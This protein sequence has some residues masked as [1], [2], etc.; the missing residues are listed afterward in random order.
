MKHRSIA[1][2]LGVLSVLGGCT[3]TTVKPAT[4]KAAPAVAP[5]K[6]RAI[7]IVQP[8]RYT[9]LDSVG[10]SLDEATEFSPDRARTPV[11]I[12]GERLIIE[13]GVLAETTNFPDSLSG[14]RSMPPRLGGGY[15]VWSDEHTYHT[16]T[17]LGKLTP[18]A[19]IGARG[20]VRTWFDSFVLRTSIGALEVNPASFTVRRTELARFAEMISLDGQVGVRTD[21]VGR[22]EASVDGG[23]TFRTLEPSELGNY[24]GPTVGPENKLVFRRE[25][26][27]MR[28][29]TTAPE[30][31]TL[32]PSGT[33]IPFEPK[34]NENLSL[35][36]FVISPDRE[37]PAPTSPL[38]P[39]EM[40]LAVVAGALVPG[41]RV[42]FVQE[43]NVRVLS[44][45][46][47]Q[48]IHN[49]PLNSSV[50][51]MGNCQ[52]ITIGDDIFLACTHA[53]GAHLLAL[54]GTPTTPQLEATFP[55]P[56]EFVAGL[57][58]R[59]LFSG[60]C[61]STPPTVRDFRDYAAPR[62]DQAEGEADPNAGSVDLPPPPEDS[63]KQ[64]VQDISVCVRL[65][66]GTWIERRIE[67]LSDRV[68]ARFLPGDDGT[69]TVVYF[70]KQG[71]DA[72]PPKP[73]EG[74]RVIRVDSKAAKFGV[75]NL[76]TPVEAAERQLQL[77]A[78]NLWLDEKDGSVHGWTLAPTKAKARGDKDDEKDPDKDAENA[79]TET[80]EEEPSSED[81]E[82]EE[83]EVDRYKQSKFVGVQ[84]N[85]DGTIVKHPLPEDADLVVV[86]GPYALARADHYQS[87]SYFESTDGGRTYTPVAGPPANNLPEGI[88]GEIEGCSVIGCA[89]RGGLVR[90]GWGSATKP[91]VATGAKTSK[92][93]DLQALTSKVFDPAKLLPS[94][95]Q[96]TLVCRL[97]GKE[98]ESETATNAPLPVTAPMLRNLELGA[99]VDRK[100]STAATIPF[101]L[102]PAFSVSFED[103]K[104]DSIQ[105]GVVS[106]LRSTANNPVGIFLRSN[107][108]R[109]DLSPGGK[110]KPI[111][112]P[113]DVRGDSAAEIDR[114]TFV[115]FD[116]RIG[117]VQLVKG[118]TVR[119]L[120]RIAQIPDVYF[121]SMVLARRAGA[122]S[123]G[124]GVL[125]WQSGSGDMLLGELD[126]GRATLGP[127]RFVGNFEE[128]MVSTSCP[129][130]DRDYRA[131]LSEH[132]SV[133]FEPLE[134][135]RMG[136]RAMSLVRVGPKGI[137]V[138]A[139][140][141]HMID[142]TTLVVRY[143]GSDTAGHP[144]M[145]HKRGKSLPATCVY[146]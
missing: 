96:R 146:E 114:D 80:G 41:E 18:I 140:E 63:D 53:T 131:V 22:M 59:F 16:P 70:D 8:A 29:G 76:Y 132:I 75:S 38:A 69:V 60:R 49:I 39:P 123:D 26:G 126:L 118:S 52:P 112:L 1:G 43:M 78:R 47:G 3:A 14:F 77:V 130:S 99:A 86:G 89:L 106:I 58:R 104:I 65:A 34:A 139:S 13:N 94:K 100:W 10:V 137:C 35:S 40:R 92:S 42:L 28:P 97:N 21:S 27:E 115:L 61:G 110:R 125:V 90:L 55:E 82:S 108:F 56:G 23:K 19:K 95:P 129:S 24:V 128:R 71:T 2:V 83:P 4:K 143:S 9:L 136:L 46:T 135:G 133:H 91:E 120:L 107:D 127:L 7:T 93:E 12:N 17:F 141:V 45:K 124:L 32:G 54:R 87:Q 30:M 138:D 85:S 101:E 103:L 142:E 67:G 64:P 57:G 74:V 121:S 11:I 5:A 73:S 105:G 145:L 122:G 68:H 15:V 66:D 116:S 134:E 144:A 20:G 51:E 88:G 81:G 62:G 25:P 117:E 50:P 102:K 79:E 31:R 44:A 33:L 6:P 48:F 98:P 111:A 72:S 84:I 109:F 37:E 36:P 119:P 113:S